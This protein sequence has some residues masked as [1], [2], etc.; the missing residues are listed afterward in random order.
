MVGKISAVWNRSWLISAVV[1]FTVHGCKQS[2][3]T[4][5]KSESESAALTTASTGQQGDPNAPR[6]QALPPEQ[7]FGAR[8]AP[9]VEVERPPPKTGVCAF[10]ENSYDGQDTRSE[11]KMVVKIKDDRIVQVTYRYRGSYSL[12]GT[13]QPNVPLRE[14]V[15]Q[16]FEF[17]LSSG[18]GKFR[19][20]LDG[21][22]M[23]FKG[24][25]ADTP[26]GECGWEKPEEK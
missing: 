25:A 24:T 18:T 9:S 1:L 19:V 7:A 13:G 22:G 17:P 4:P 3:D 26:Q 15:W 20:K 6:V 23:L 21:N 11:E 14:G 2:K 16:S 8:G 12:D 5:A 10:Q